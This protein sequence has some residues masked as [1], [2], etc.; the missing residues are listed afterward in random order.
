MLDIAA[1]RQA[2]AATAQDDT[3]TDG[4]VED[5]GP[6]EFNPEPAVTF[7][8][9]L[10]DVAKAYDNTKHPRGPNGRFLAS[11]EAVFGAKVAASASE[12]TRTA[13]NDIQTLHQRGRE[14]L[15]E[16]YTS[17]TGRPNR[18]VERYRDHA[19]TSLRSE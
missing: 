17:P 7:A 16:S 5:E 19:L 8:E 12:H 11:P 1:L 14:D 2:L 3:P 13:W 10:R 6:E 15:L 4:Y 18:L 9:A